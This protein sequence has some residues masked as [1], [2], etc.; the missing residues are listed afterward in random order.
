MNLKTMKLINFKRRFEMIWG[1]EIEEGLMWPASTDMAIGF[2]MIRNI[3]L[4]EDDYYTNLS[5][6][7]E[8]INFTIDSYFLEHINND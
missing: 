5:Y 2:N 1:D 3:N 6:Y 7:R 4:L 8:V